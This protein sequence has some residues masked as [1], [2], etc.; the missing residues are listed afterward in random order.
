M[1][2]DS[3]TV[4]GFLI[5]EGS[6]AVVNKSNVVYYITFLK[7]VLVGILSIRTVNTAEDEKIYRK[8]CVQPSHEKH[9]RIRR[10]KHE[11]KI[12]NG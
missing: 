4:K 6:N 8:I 7:T 5:Y 9:L 12:G 1:C 10:G 2:K 3:D 11:R